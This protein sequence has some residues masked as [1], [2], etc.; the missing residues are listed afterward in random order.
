[1]K[2]TLLT[3]LLVLA[4][5]FT[6]TFTQNTFAQIQQQG[7]QPWL[8]VQVWNF[9]HSEVQP[10]ARVWVVDYNGN[11]LLGSDYTN[12][13]GWVGFSLLGFG[14]G[15]YIIHAVNQAGT[16]GGNTYWTYSG[17]GS[18]NEEVILNII[19]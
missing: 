12:S 4:A 11:T 15:S 10:N 16:I 14:G 1:M 7:G 6:L 9:D 18:D 19:W 5:L 17:S 3:A 2:K 13:E 8:N